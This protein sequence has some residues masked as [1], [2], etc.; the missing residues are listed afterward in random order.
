M[1]PIPLIL[2]C[3]F[4][5]HYGNAAFAWLGTGC[6][7]HTTGLDGILGGARSNRNGAMSRRNPPNQ[8]FPTV[9][10]GFGG[11]LFTVPLQTLFKPPLQKRRKPLNSL[12]FNGFH[13]LREQD[14]NL[15]PS[16]YEPDELPGC[17]I[18]RFEWNRALTRGGDYGR[19][20]AWQSREILDF[21]E[22]IGQGSLRFL[23]LWWCSPRKS[24]PNSRS[25]SRQTACMWLASF[26][27][28]AASIRKVGP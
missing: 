20:S 21:P 7:V 15:R 4:L 1:V 5:T 16:G 9:V 10:H 23:Y 13:W 12:E 2:G 24:R 28:L 11:C 17:S 22:K 18:P 26:W 3:T 14:L 6:R 25:E 19:R 27:V 8:P